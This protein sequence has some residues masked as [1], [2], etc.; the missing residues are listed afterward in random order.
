MNDH[1]RAALDDVLRSSVDAGEVPGAVAMVVDRDSI[2]Y[3]NAVGVMD[4][5]G[6]EAMRLDAI[7][8][9]FSM[10][11][12]ITSLGIM[13][14]QEEGLLSLDDPASDY[15]PELA[16]RE[17]L[18][19][20]DTDNSS[21][22]TRPASRP[23][24]IRDLLRHTSGFGYAF[25]SPEVLEI[26]SNS[27]I[28]AREYPI[29]HDP[30]VRWTYGMS[31]AFLGWIIEEISEQS[32]PEFLSSRILDPLEMT[33]TSFDLA[34]ENYVR[35]VATYQ[36][37]DTG[38]EGQPRPDQYHA[39]VRGDYGLLSTANDYTRF[40]QLILGGGER[41]GTR[42]LSETSISEMARDQLEDI[43][44][45]EQPSTLPYKSRAFPLGA[46]KDG[47]GLGFQVSV[48]QSAGGRPP[49]T[50]SWA[51]IRNT[52]FWIDPTNGIGVVLLLQLLPFYDK[53]AI[54]IMTTFERTLY[55][56]LVS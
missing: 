51:G 24:T 23:I 22:I 16:D 14:L 37:T 46:S 21:A 48:G 40:V 34:D 45:V 6:T 42:V 41:G 27:S 8:R 12:P 29:L 49:G 26:S 20:V 1:T 2:L 9:I 32:L 56:G 36:R 18:V 11:K 3:S 25:S 35:L 38:M 54:D 13:I 4:S 43:T 39:I 28:P 19:S 7:F 5:A 10:T 33:D 44:V 47:F 17:V 55:D 50:L 53:K 15:L 30:G 52:H 31:T